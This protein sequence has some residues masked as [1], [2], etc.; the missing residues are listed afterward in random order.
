[1]GAYSMPFGH[2][3]RTMRLLNAFMQHTHVLLAAEK[4]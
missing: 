3:F 1:M 4:D 2:P